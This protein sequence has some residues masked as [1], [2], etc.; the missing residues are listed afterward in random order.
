[1]IKINMEETFEEYLKEQREDLVYQ[2]SKYPVQL[3]ID[4]RVAIDSMLIAYDQAVEK[5]LR[6]SNAIESL[7]N[8]E[9]V[10]AWVEGLPY[11][12]SCT[13]EYNEGFEEG[14]AWLKEKL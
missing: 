5:A 8:E 2:V 4:L 9:E 11:Y 13:I 1:M 7:P 12:G 10:K 3:H 6:P 14:V